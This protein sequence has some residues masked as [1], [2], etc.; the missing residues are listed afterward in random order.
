M[1]T[2]LKK[3]QGELRARV[4]AFKDELATVRTNRPAARLIENIIVEYY[5]QRMTIQQIGSISVAP[6]REMLLHI[7]DKNAIAPAVK[8]IEAARLGLSIAVDGATIRLTL[9][10]LN[11]ERRTELIKMVKS[12]TEKQRIAVRG[13]RDD[14]NKKVRTLEHDEDVQFDVKQR[15]Q[16]TVDHTN[17]EFEELLALKMKE[18]WE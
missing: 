14:I 17:K 10:P 1:D 9:P 8:G 15:I 13:L 11:D 2:E 16:K 5:N 12:M 4:V 7:W 6:P 3:F 18:I